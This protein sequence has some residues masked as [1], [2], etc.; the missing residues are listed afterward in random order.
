[1]AGIASVQKPSNVYSD[2]HGGLNIRD[3]WH[4]IAD[5]E[6][7]VAQ[8]I[9]YDD[10]AA[11][12]PKGGWSKLIATA[13]P[14]TNP[15][16]GGYHASFEIAGVLT[17]YVVATDGTDVYYWTGSA[18][19]KIT[20]VVTLNPA[21]NGVVRFIQMNNLLIGY[22]GVNLP[23][24][25][26]GVSGAIMSMVGAPIAS[27][28]IVF[29][30]QIYWSGI[31]ATPTTNV[32]S[33]LGD[34]TTYGTANTF[35]TPS[36]YDGD[37]ITG[38]QI[39]YGNLFIFKRNSIYIVQVNS[40][41]S[42]T[43]SKTNAAI[44]CVSQDSV[45]FVDNLIYFVS[46]KGLYAA[47][48]YQVKELS[49]KVAPRYVNAVTNQLAGALT[50]NR[51]MGYHYRQRNEIWMAI[52]ATVNGQTQHDRVMTHNY[53]VTDQ[54]GDPA[55]AEHITGN[56]VTAPSFMADYFQ[57]NNN[58]RPMASFYDKYL[59]VF[60]EGYNRDD[61]P[62]GTGAFV[63]P[64]MFTKFFDLG[65]PNETKTVRS[66]WMQ[67]SVSGGAPIF[68]ITKTIDL[69]TLNGASITSGSIYNLRFDVGQILSPAQGKFFRF[70]W[71]SND[72][73]TFSFFQFQLDII[74]SGRRH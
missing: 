19:T 54:N 8:N 22:D 66:I 58:I 73:G 59:Y 7:T 44:G 15:L 65:D 74:H 25:W 52:D 4:R 64:Q 40:D 67:A 45:I 49:Y 57:A 28:A 55:V 68:S 39:L 42:F 53:E 10:R 14:T 18:W 34:P 3:F 72:G 37:P 61:I 29:N 38:Y 21:A 6:L 12:Q 35:L 56:T 69:A 23:W 27:I 47:N 70:G 48:L 11:I 17:R 5:N 43:Q 60:T 32:G 9:R 33:N 36:A 71:L 50:G 1:M 16:I 20:G 13:V 51:I 24:S 63:A 26:D 46:D 62:S 31:A 41:G 2:F 30:N